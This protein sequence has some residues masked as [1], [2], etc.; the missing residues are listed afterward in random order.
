[1]DSLGA[2]GS[3]WITGWS[4]S[5]GQ[6]A[7]VWG[8]RAFRSCHN[9][10]AS[11][12][13]THTS[14]FT[15]NGPSQRDCPSSSLDCPPNASGCFKDQI[16][17]Q[18]AKSCYIKSTQEK[19]TQACWE[20]MLRIKSKTFHDEYLERDNTHV[21]MQ[22]L[23]YLFACQF[24][25]LI[26]ITPFLAFTLRKC[27]KI[28]CRTI[29]WMKRIENKRIWNNLEV[30]TI[31]WKMFRLWKSGRAGFKSWHCLLLSMQPQAI[32]LNY[33]RVY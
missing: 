5:S 8:A 11:T 13:N 2:V 29:L 10:P 17:S 32:F 21:N 16:S 12:L 14:F 1:M 23:T 33:L 30:S 25:Y 7:G 22:V 31:C 3:K 24:N 15:K 18:R 6:M 9:G 4:W 19:E 27:T 28:G 26:V 20:N